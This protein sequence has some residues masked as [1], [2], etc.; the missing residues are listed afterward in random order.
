MVGLSSSIDSK[1]VVVGGILTIAIADAFSDSLGMHISEESEGKHSKKEIWAS[2]IATFL[3]KLL[4]AMTFLVPVFLF[5]L[6]TAIN[7]SIVW[8]LLWLAAIS[9]WMAKDQKEKPMNA[10]LEHLFIAV[11]VIVITHFVGDFIGKH[12]AG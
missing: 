10:V 3:T 11:M 1:M 6:S 5:R 9:V 7:I 8:G 4:F 2:T 12:F